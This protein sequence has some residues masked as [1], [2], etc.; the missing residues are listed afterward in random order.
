MSARDTALAES[1]QA[2]FCSMADYLGWKKS[3]KVLNFEKYP[4]FEKF[5]L[6]N[7]TNLKEALK[8]VKVDMP[9]AEIYK[10]LEN[11][12]T[13]LGWYKSSILIANKVVKDLNV[14]VD[15]QFS[16][17]SPGYNDGQMWYLRGDKMVMEIIGK[18][19]KVAKQSL[20]TKLLENDLPQV[21]GFRDIN[22][23]NPADIYFANGNAK[24]AL[25][26]ELKLSMKDGTS[27][28]FEDLNTRIENLIDSGDLLPLSLKKTTK[29]V[30][31]V[32][33][34]FSEDIKSKLLRKV[35]YDGMSPWTPFKRLAKT[36][37]GSWSEWK[38]GKRTATRDLRIMIKLGNNTKGE[39]K[40]RHD[41]SGA[42]GRFVIEFIGGGA[43]ARGGSVGSPK[44]FAKIWSAIDRGAG[45]NFLKL[46]DKGRGLANGGGGNIKFVELKK[47]YSEADKV[48]LRKDK[49]GNVSAYDHYMAIHS[50]ENII[51]EVMPS[52]VKWFK[53]NPRKRHK[54]VRLLFQYVTS[55][56]PLSARFIIAKG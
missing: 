38:R 18:L 44:L 23:W 26:D 36:P 56:D 28:T 22:K 42:A 32:R 46:Y 21:I 48:Q 24:R 3:E 53:D 4:D 2:I 13:G 34:N 11:G 27:Y 35:Q 49:I 12:Q 5:Q 37:R 33:V 43:E 39:I 40:L 1:A 47:S 14:E 7:K 9:I 17:R 15:P 16:I 20:I 8:R 52:T 31:L 30:K 55:R 51:N 54:F 25:Q 41:P 50:A 10:F 29:S 6:H 45:E 19:F